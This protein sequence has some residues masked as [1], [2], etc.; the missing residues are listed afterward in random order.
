MAEHPNATA[1]R[2]LFEAFEKRDIAAVTQ[3]IAEDAVWRFPGRRGQIAGAHHG[4]AGI[5]AFLAKVMAL[6]NGTFHL[7]ITD[8]AASD[9]RAVVLFTGRGE[10]DGKQLNNPTCLNVRMVNGRAVE[11]AEFVWDLEHVE[12]FWA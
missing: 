6:T 10:R 12:D 2:R 5:L 11:F 7:E 8:V 9:D 3:L 4:H 1:M